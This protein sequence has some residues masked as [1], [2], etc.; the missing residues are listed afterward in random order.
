MSDKNIKNKSEIIEKQ[1]PLDQNF[2]QL[3]RND[4]LAMQVPLRNN[5]AKDLEYEKR[6][7]KLEANYENL[8][9]RFS[10]NF[11]YIKD[12]ISQVKTD[13]KHIQGKIDNINSKIDSNYKYF[14]GLFITIILGFV[15]IYFK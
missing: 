13:I 8:D 5:N 4:S 11:Q 12:D 10:E 14:F 6:L 15:A 1:I 7:T 9:K 3:N 2:E